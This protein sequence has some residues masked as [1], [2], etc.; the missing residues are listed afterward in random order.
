MSM[1]TMRIFT[2]EE[3]EKAKKAL[4]KEDAEKAEMCVLEVKEKSGSVYAIVI[5]K[6]GSDFYSY[7]VTDEL[8]DDLSGY[9]VSISSIDGIIE[10]LKITQEQ[11]IQEIKE[12]IS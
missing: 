12:Y 2:K 10:E 4:Y 5:Q 3:N 6:H 7:W 1:T 11:L 8:F 9:S